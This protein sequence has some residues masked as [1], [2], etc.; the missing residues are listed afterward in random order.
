LRG[1]YSLPKLPGY[2]LPNDSIRKEYNQI[3]LC[4]SETS[5]QSASHL[6]IPSFLLSRIS[7]ALRM[8]ITQGVI[9]FLVT[10][11]VWTN[12]E[13]ACVDVLIAVEDIINGVYLLISSYMLARIL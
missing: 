10:S 4:A 2:L 11:G 9:Y 13:R 6:G 8:N 5:L 7:N 3:P 12:H 1:I